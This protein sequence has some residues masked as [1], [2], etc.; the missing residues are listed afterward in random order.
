MR[1][2]GY[3]DQNIAIRV[4]SYSDTNNW[5]FCYINLYMIFVP[6]LHFDKRAWFTEIVKDE[7]KRGG[8]VRRKINKFVIALVGW[9]YPGQF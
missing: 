4:W 8:N 7:E 1:I 2:D 6:N 3:L 5:N 9:T